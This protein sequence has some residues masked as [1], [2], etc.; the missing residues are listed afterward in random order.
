MEAQCCDRAL[1]LQPVQLLRL[2]QGTH[3]EL[4]R[5]PLVLSWPAVT[6]SSFMAIGPLALEAAGFLGYAWMREQNNALETPEPSLSQ[7]ARSRRK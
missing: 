4:T 7:R 6:E 2:E 5:T 1:S 3:E